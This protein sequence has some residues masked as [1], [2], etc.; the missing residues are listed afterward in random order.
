[1]R[2]TDFETMHIVTPGGAA[3]AA[4]APGSW[5]WGWG[6]GRIRN[7]ETTTKGLGER[8]GSRAGKGTG[9]GK[10]KGGLEEGE[11]GTSAGG[12]YRASAFGNHWYG[13]RGLEQGYPCGW[14]TGAV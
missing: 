2:P 5:G 10:G 12:C 13:A 8:E 4:G 3:P 14:G 1:M 11:N 9:K 6:K 7:R